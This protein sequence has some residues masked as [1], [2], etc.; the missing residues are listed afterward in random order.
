MKI[1]RAT[2]RMVGLVLYSMLVL[3]CQAPSTTEST[4]PSPESR[5]TDLASIYQMGLDTT[6]AIDKGEFYLIEKDIA[7]E[8]SN[9]RPVEPVQGLAKSSQFRIISGNAAVVDYSRLADIKILIDPSIDNNP[10]APIWRE[11]LLLAISD[12]NAVRNSAVRFRIVTSN[13]DIIIKMNMNSKF[14]D[15]GAYSYLPSGGKPGNLVVVNYYA[16]KSPGPESI[17]AHELGHAI[18]WAHVFIDRNSP[19]GQFQILGTPSATNDPPSV[20]G[21]GRF[22]VIGD[23]NWSMLT[24]GD[25]YA[26][27]RMYGKYYP[28]QMSSYVPYP[29][30]SLKMMI[31]DG[32]N[33]YII[34]GGYLRGLGGAGQGDGSIVTSQPFSAVKG[35]TFLNGDIYVSNGNK[36]FKV[37]RFSGQSTQLPGLDTSPSQG[38]ITLNGIIYEF[39]DITIRQIN[40]TTGQRTNVMGIDYKATPNTLTTDGYFIYY[41]DFYGLIVRLDPV[42]K[43]FINQGQERSFADATSMGVLGDHFYVMASNQLWRV[44]KGSFASNTSPW[45]HFDPISWRNTGWTIVN[46]NP[47]F[48]GVNLILSNRYQIMYFDG[49]IY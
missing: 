30:S 49:M 35:M 10:E 16:F 8:K 21:Y 19:K 9:L 7:I 25:K 46:T 43:K 33:T 36:I 47:G 3:A 24:D 1:Q 15:P 12:Y 27:E 29:S 44:E 45:G 14:S 13:P 31:S 38:I 18:G 28:I 5:S 20:M 23:P 6:G 48:F 42:A 34:C 32:P 22:P 37:D 17:F 11:G 4:P 2:T 40:A 39:S 41:V 26:L